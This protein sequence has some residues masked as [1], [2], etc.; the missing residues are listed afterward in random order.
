AAGVGAGGVGVLQRCEEAALGGEAGA[1][2][3]G[4]AEVGAGA[5][6]LDGDSA[7]VGAVGPLGAVDGAHPPLAEPR[8]E[9]PRPDGAAYRGVAEGAAV[10]V[11]EG[12]VE[13]AG[14]LGGVVRRQQRADLG[15]EGVVAHGP[16]GE[17]GVPLALG[18]VER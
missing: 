2:G 5:D 16:G 8:G 17:E 18:P 12:A 7:L 6:E 4:R 10:A 15:G 11:E 14:G 9:P 1:E 13:V 3:G